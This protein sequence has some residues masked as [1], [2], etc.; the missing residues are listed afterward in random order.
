MTDSP[1]H[2]S[3]AADRAANPGARFSHPLE[4]RSELIGHA[5]GAAVG[6]QRL[7][8]FMLRIPPGK[9]S[10]PYHRHHGE[11][12][13]VF[14]V[15]GSGVVE[16]EGVDYPITAGDFLGFPAA[17]GTAHQIRNDGSD[18]LVY[19]TVGEHNP[20][21]VAEFP[22]LHKYLVRIGPKTSVFDAEDG[23]GLPFS[24]RLHEELPKP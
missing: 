23:S 14:V 21:E 2:L 20:L 1:K 13:V 12:E 18:D 9:T 4:P 10:F 5:L 22:R 11:E 3:R 16:I 24:V 6:L 7:G 15:S 8:A 19:L 17:A